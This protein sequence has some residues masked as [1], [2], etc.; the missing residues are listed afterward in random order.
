ME[1]ED[2]HQLLNLEGNMTSLPTLRKVSTYRLEKQGQIP[3]LGDMWIHV[4]PILLNHF[5]RIYLLGVE[6][7]LCVG[8]RMLRVKNI[9]LKVRLMSWKA[10][11]N[12]SLE[13]QWQLDSTNEQYFV[14]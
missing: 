2:G 9:G 12:D 14:L 6:D 7:L 3:R 5:V 13:F 8:D 4:F 10:C 11:R 1:Q